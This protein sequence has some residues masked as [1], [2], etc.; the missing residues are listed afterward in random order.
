M[1]RIAGVRGIHGQGCL[2]L[3]YLGKEVLLHDLLL[4]A[5]K[6]KVSLKS[7]GSVFPSL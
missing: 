7:S 5:H 1:Q 4:L 3:I 6:R 2:H